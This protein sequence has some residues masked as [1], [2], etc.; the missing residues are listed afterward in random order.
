MK[1]LLSLGVLL[2]ALFGVG[3]ALA[4]SA[5][6]HASVV[7]SDPVDGSRLKAVHPL[8]HRAPAVSGTW[9]SL[10]GAVR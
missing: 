1:R 3:V 7:A 2:G 6:A 4:A 9:S 8:V 10:R 5:S